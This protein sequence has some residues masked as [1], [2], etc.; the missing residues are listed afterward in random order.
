MKKDVP[1]CPSSSCEEGNLLLGIV[2]REG[3]VELL[4]E[5]MEIDQAFV[6]IAHQGREPRQRFRFTSPCAQGACVQWREGRCGVG[7]QM[8]KLVTPEELDRPLPA[9]V[10]RPQCRWYLQSGPNICHICPEVIDTR[11]L[12]AP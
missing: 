2:G 9:C 4:P 5:P 10:I 8:I 6:Q 7:D 12:P 3:R 11:T 1:L